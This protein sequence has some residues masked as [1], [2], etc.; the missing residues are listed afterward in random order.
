MRETKRRGEIKSLYLYIE[1]PLR[2]DDSVTD[3]D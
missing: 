1:R 3:A 2:D